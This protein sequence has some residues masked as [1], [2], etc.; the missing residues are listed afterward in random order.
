MSWILAHVG[1]WNCHWECE[2]VWDFERSSV[3]SRLIFK[4]FVSH[5]GT[6]NA[7][8]CKNAEVPRITQSRCKTALFDKLWHNI[9]DIVISEQSI[10]RSSLDSAPKDILAFRAFANSIFIPFTGL[11]SKV[12]RCK[13]F[14]IKFH[15]SGCLNWALDRNGGESLEAWV[16][17][18]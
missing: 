3:V 7:G 17:I 4:F 6:E 8:I 16:S 12:I 2:W 15:F 14:L 11:E 9:R 13:Q 18:R 5:D 10:S 1:L